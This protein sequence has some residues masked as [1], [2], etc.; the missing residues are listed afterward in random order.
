M[1]VYDRAKAAADFILSKVGRIPETA[2]V[3]GSGL[4][5]FGDSIEQEVVIPYGEIPQFPVSTVAGHKGQMIFGRV[6]GKPIVAMQGRFHRYEGYELTDVT[7]YIRVFALLG[8]KN[9]ILTNAAGAINTSFVPGDLMLISD[10]ISLFCDSPLFGENDE[11]F[12]VRFPSMSY[13]Y[14]R[15]LQALAERTAEQLNIGLQ[16]GIYLYAKGPMYETPAEI[17]AMRVLGADACGMSTVPETIVAVHSGIRVLGISC[18]TNMAAGILDQ[19]LSHAEVVE[20]GKA[21]EQKFKAL[22]TGIIEKI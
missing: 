20:C 11:R 19:P 13:A 21:V 22:I 8:V 12:G 18:L 15:E 16:K 2:V 4:G 5:A 10:H 14:D 3:L 9:L 6:Q 7:L 1:T 17:R